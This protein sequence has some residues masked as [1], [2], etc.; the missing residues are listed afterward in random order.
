MPRGVTPNGRTTLLTRVYI[1]HSRESSQAFHAHSHTIRTVVATLASYSQLFS[2]YSHTI[3]TVA[4]CSHGRTLFAHC[5]HGRTLFAQSHTIRT[6]FARS[7]TIRAVHTLFTHYSRHRHT[8]LAHYSHPFAP[9][10][11]YSRGGWGV[12][13]VRTHSRSTLTVHTRSH[14]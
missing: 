11:H 13:S 1:S 14:L 5:S 2:H 7:H 10:S 3:R 12:R 9:R 8:K 6:R 4:H